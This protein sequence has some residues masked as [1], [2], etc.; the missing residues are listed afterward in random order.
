MGNKMNLVSPAEE[1]VAVKVKDPVMVMQNHLLMAMLT[2]GVINTLFLGGFVNHTNDYE[3][4]TRRNLRN[5]QEQ[6]DGLF[7]MVLMTAPPQVKARLQ[8]FDRKRRLHESN[9]NSGTIDR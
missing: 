9:R 5:Q 8:E 4:I 1:L 6:I 7:A 2:V 3:E